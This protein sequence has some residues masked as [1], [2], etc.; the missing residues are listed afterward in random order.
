MGFGHGSRGLCRNSLN[1]VSAMPNTNP[2]LRTNHAHAPVFDAPGGV[3]SDRRGLHRLR[4]GAVVV[5]GRAADRWFRRIGGSWTAPVAIPMDADTRNGMMALRPAVS[6]LGASQP[7]CDKH[8][9]RSFARPF[10]NSC[11]TDCRA[12]YAAPHTLP[13]G[14]LWSEPPFLWFSRCQ[15][16]R[17]GAMPCVCMQ[18]IC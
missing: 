16:V 11:S 17:F 8:R 4:E 18:K 13:N 9:G 14:R 15:F 1:R 10:P 12:W 7:A 5:A 2:L 3:A 6:G